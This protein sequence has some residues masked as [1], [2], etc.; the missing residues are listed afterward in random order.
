MGPL[1]RE[2]ANVV[3]DAAL[4]A[5]SQGDVVLGEQWFVFRID[6]VSPLTKEACAAAAEGAE[7][8]EVSVVGLVVVTQTCDLVRACTERPFVEVCP[9]VTVDEAALEDVERGRRVSYAYIPS[10]A[11]RNLVADLDRVM[12]VEKSVIA[13]WERV[14]GCRS[15]EERRKFARSLARKRVRAAFPDDFVD[16]V[17]PL[18][19]RLIKKHDRQSEEGD[20]LRALREIR[21]RAAPSWDANEV[22]LQFWF[23]RDEPEPAFAGKTWDN[24]LE[25]WFE[26]IPKSGRFVRVFGLVQTLVDLSAREYVESDVL[27]LDHLSSVAD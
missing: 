25:K 22:E 23:V 3:T 9:L 4:Q 20:A 26:L 7:N 14:S 24:Y 1:E 5:W 12:T 19:K 17:K 2:G 27:D 13:G 18:Q 21:V 16:F 11:V 6:P 10:L 15:D 8:A